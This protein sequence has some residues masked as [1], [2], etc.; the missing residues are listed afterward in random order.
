MEIKNFFNKYNRTKITTGLSKEENKFNRYEEARQ[1]YLDQYMKQSA[2]IHSWKMV[3]IFSLTMCFISLLFVF[4]LSSRSSLIPYVIEVDET[5]N[6]KGIN[7]AYQLNYNPTEANKEYHLRE[8]IKRFRSLSSDVELV[9][10]FY[11]INTNFMTQSTRKKYDRLIHQEDISALFKEGFTRQ[12]Q[13]NSITK[14]TNNSNSYQVRWT[15]QLFDVEG[16]VSRIKKYTGIF[17]L[18]VETP[19]TLEVLA[20]NP[21]GIM[22]TDFSISL[23]KQ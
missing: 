7:P 6:A 8:F 9:N 19:K 18:N 10:N 13:I 12:V 16:K 4:Y 22:I 1:E 21:L 3:A 20:I 17:S 2:S 23:D 11:K 14:L 15:E 5:G